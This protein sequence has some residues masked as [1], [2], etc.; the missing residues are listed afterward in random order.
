[1]PMQQGDGN[2]VLLAIELR[3]MPLACL[4]YATLLLR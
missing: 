2:E 3:A 4:H 1:M